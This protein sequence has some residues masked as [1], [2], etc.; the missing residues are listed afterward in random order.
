[1]YITK[2]FRTKTNLDEWLNSLSLPTIVGY[3]ACWLGTALG[4]EITVTVKVQ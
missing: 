1:M 3:Q 2:S 4:T